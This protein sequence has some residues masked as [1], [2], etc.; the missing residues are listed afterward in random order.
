MKSPNRRGPNFLIAYL[1]GKLSLGF[2]LFGT[3]IWD[4][5]INNNKEEMNKTDLRIVPFEFSNYLIKSLCALAPLGI[6]NGYG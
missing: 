2:R 5:P 4:I 1:V 3:G 6:L